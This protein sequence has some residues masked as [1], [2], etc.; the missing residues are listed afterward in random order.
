MLIQCTKKLLDQMKIKPEIKLPVEEN[1]LFSWHANLIKFNRKN[2][3]V[4]VNDKNRYI[5][6]LYALKAK[7]FKNLDKL[8]INAIKE[9]FLD[10]CIK[11]AIIDSLLE[12]SGSIIYTKTKN[13]ISIARM[14]QSIGIVNHFEDLVNE[15]SKNQSEINKQLGYFIVGKGNDDYLHPKEELI[16]N[17]EE[18]SKQSIF[19]TK[20]FVVKIKLDLDNH[21]VWRKLV[22]PYN[23][24]F[25]KLH[26]IL[27]IVFDWQDYHLH[28]F[29]VFGE[30]KD[31]NMNTKPNNS[32]HT[33]E[34]Y[35]P[36][37]NLV[38]NEESLDYGDENLTKL[39][40]GYKLSE[41]NWVKIKYIYDFGDNW[42]HFIDIE[43][44][45][46]KYDKNYPICLD[47]EGSAPPEDVGGSYGYDE[48]LEIT[49]D[50][51]NPKQEG[52]LEW[53]K[54]LGYGEFNIEDINSKLKR[55]R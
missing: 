11:E 15:N 34:S 43:E 40:I 14:N 37:V 47:G 6:V 18:F 17:L 29:W 39:D 27:Q 53:G 10:E 21:N 50:N 48:F 52:M 22:I 55:I 30:D 3:V 42:V 33:L 45:L 1:E 20:A 31:K 46:E 9:T 54:S 26:E 24:T 44:K 23:T 4:L 49:N 16:K 8:I 7:D 28:E 2:T 35:K 12:S 36:I 38:Y 25:S 51:N 19:E 5:I 32:A 41:Y 13:R